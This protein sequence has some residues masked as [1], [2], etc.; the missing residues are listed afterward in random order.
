MS[1]RDNW[2]FDCVHN[3]LI[4]KQRHQIMVEEI[5]IA[6]LG[7]HYFWDGEIDDDFWQSMKRIV[8]N[9]RWTN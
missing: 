3:S 2:F 7:A 6:N 9:S 1:D 4:R 8:E 5:Y